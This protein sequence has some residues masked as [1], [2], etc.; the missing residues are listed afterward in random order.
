MIQPIVV[1]GDPILR[2]SAEPYTVGTDL[3]PIIQDLWDTMYNAKGAG[4][5]APQIGLPTK[6]FVVHLP[7]IAFKRT[8]INPVITSESGEEFTI[9]EGCLSI[10]GAEGPVKRKSKIVIEYYDEA[11]TLNREEFEGLE[12][13]VIQHEYDHLLGK[14]WVDQMEWIS[15]RERL[16]IMTSLQHCQTK[17]IKADYPIA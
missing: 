6:L 2:K 16:I 4:L 15:A 1:Y 9:L 13:R 5:A 12:A 11:W 17:S 7:N 10:P 8:F 14:L 3:K